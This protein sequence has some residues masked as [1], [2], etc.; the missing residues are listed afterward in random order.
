MGLNSSENA[1]S[2]KIRALYG[3]R[4]TKSQFSELCYKGSVFEIIGFLKSI[5]LYKK[6]FEEI[7]E[8]SEHIQL[9]EDILTKSILEVYSSLSKFASKESKEFFKSF[10][11]YAECESI[12]YLVKLISYG[13]QESFKSK[14]P[15]DFMPYKGFDIKA[16]YSVEN[17]NQLLLALKK[18]VYF[19]A[20]KSVPIDSSGKPNFFYCECYLRR[21][22]YKVLIDT[23]KKLYKGKAKDQIVSLFSLEAELQNLVTIGKIKKLYD[24]SETETKKLLVD[25]SFKLS[26]QKLEKLVSSKNEAE[27]YGLL[28]LTP[29][30]FDVGS[31]YS[32]EQKCDETILSESKKAIVYGGENP[33][34]SF[35]GYVLFKSIEVKNLKTII[36]GISSNKSPDKIFKSLIF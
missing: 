32:L 18:T 23:I 6:D 28:N 2:A 36:H 8:S 7:N 17:Y 16:L 22:Y 34:L 5:P 9:V 3:K 26:K 13:Q 31:L 4:I 29:Y 24:I 21:L 30:N 20:L 15:P 10:F 12:E 1:L 14:I 27:Y 19:D 35:S 11:F 33:P 25:L